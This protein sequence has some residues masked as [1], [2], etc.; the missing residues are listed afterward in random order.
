MITDAWTDPGFESLAELL[1]RRTGLAFAANR[2]ADLE[3][4]VRRAMSREGLESPAAY[5]KRLE[6]G[7]SSL[8]D[9][10]AE[11]TVGETYFL[12]EPRQFEFIRDD[13]LPSLATLREP[14]HVYRV[15]SAGC[16]SGE[17][18]YT[19]AILFE[20][21][22]LSDRVA[23]LATDISR[24]ALAAARRALFGPWSLRGLPATVVQRHFR[25]A[26]NRHEP[27]PSLRRNVRFE[28]LNLAIDRYPSLAAGIWGMD[29]ILCRNVMIYLNRETIRTVARRLAESLA[30]GGWLIPG[31]SDPP[32]NDL[33]DWEA[34]VTK[35]GVF[36]RRR[37]AV[38]NQEPVSSA[39]ASSPLPTIV[40]G[41]R[42]SAPRPMA[43]PPTIDAVRYALAAG[44]YARVVELTESLDGADA[45]A[46][47]VRALANLAG[48]KKA[49]RAAREATSRH[50]LNVEL[51]F[52]Q[53]VLLADLG[54]FDEAGASLRR[55]LFLDRSLAAAYA[56]E[57]ALRRRRGDAEGAR[58]AYRNALALCSVRRPDEPI[59][60]SDGEP[61]GRLAHAVRVELEL[62]EGRA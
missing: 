9:L 59:E 57:G 17:E 5:A 1:A 51:H 15:W 19:L 10:V 28:Y 23:I 33:A 50:P 55:V 44:E 62:L 42:A 13:I 60:L 11:V 58:R 54:R 14:R 47:R 40:D 25:T 26:G 3:S 7:A 46:L 39:P 22:G 12:R 8:D 37:P 41:F 24:P 38:R 16:A 27:N 49:E 45:W 61:A 48:P 4:G 29:L 36:Y 34:V 6:S 52:L 53:A 20:E 32:L 56:L 35:S 43:V 18:A 2:R 31:P 30:P 21:A